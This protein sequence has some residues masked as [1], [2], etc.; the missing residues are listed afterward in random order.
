MIV[1]VFRARLKQDV[2]EEYYAL[3]AEVEAEADAMSGFVSR[4]ALVAEDGERVSIV[5]FEDQESH[6][7][8]AKNHLHV[9]AKKKGR[10]SFYSEYSL[11][12]C[13]VIREN[14]FVEQNR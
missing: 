1:T 14:S 10:E 11:Q 6:N 9:S 2:G 13:E 12:V 3:L 7:N 4:K 8:W 5:T